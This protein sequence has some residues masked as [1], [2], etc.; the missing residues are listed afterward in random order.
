MTTGKA[1]S[2]VLQRESVHTVQGAEELTMMTHEGL[3]VVH[4]D[5]NK[6]K[7]AQE[8]GPSQMVLS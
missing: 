4:D 8:N 2:I 1:L 3:T 6:N 7:A 5:L